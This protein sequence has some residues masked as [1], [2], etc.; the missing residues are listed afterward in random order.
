[1]NGI[2]YIKLQQDFLAE[3]KIT[4]DKAITLALARETAQR[5]QEVLDTNKQ[6]AASNKN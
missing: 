5:S 6:V 2:N 4:L 1:M 3:Q